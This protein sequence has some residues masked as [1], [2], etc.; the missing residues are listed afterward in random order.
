MA[1]GHESVAVRLGSERAWWLSAVLLAAVLAVALGSLWLG[2]A[3][4]IALGASLAAGGVIAIGLGLARP[5]DASPARRER[6]WEIQAV[7]VAVL[8]AVWLA[9]IGELG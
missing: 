3:S 5:T 8:A 1:A 2:R 7:G 6:A 4:A 9:G